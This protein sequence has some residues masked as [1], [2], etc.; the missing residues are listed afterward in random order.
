MDITGK[1]CYITGAGGFVGSHLVK[2]LNRK[3]VICIPHK[4]ITKTKLK[5]FDSLYFLSTYGNMHFHTDDRQILQANIN[6]L[7][8]LLLEAKSCG[9]KSFVYIS[10][11]SVELPIQTFYSRTKRV[12]EEILLAFIEKYNLPICIVRPFSITGVGEQKE[13][14]ISTLIRSC[15]T[16]EPVS[17]VPEPT[18]DFIDVKDVVS[19]IL[20]LSSIRAKGIFELGNGFSISNK[21]VL[22]LVEGITDKKANINIIDNLYP[23]DNNNWYS[24]DYK[25]REYNWTPRKSLEESIIEMVNEYVKRT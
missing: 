1:L 15:L 6:D 18:H 19:G 7:I 11:S 3:P 4:E 22:N 24:K 16:G 9:F 25:A 13:K 21:E 20:K 14:L 23:Y 5:P 17:F 12:A 8:H 10:T 2:A